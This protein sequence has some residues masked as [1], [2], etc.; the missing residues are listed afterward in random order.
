MTVL[1]EPV[2]VM[3]AP[4]PGLAPC[5]GRKANSDFA[6]CCG[7]GPASPASLSASP[8]CLWSVPRPYPRPQPRLAGFPLYFS[9]PVRAG[10]S[11]NHSFSFCTGVRPSSSSCESR[12]LPAVGDQGLG[13]SPGDWHRSAFEPN[14]WDSTLVGQ[15]CWHFLGFILR[16]MIEGRT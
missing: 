12:A 2:Q 16:E 5:L 6:A 14:W 13:W 3:L 8:A 7:L 10:F 15:V 11:G 9:P 1:Q 4:A